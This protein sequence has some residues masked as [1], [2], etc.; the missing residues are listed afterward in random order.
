MRRTAEAFLFQSFHKNFVFFE[1]IMAM[2]VCCQTHWGELLVDTLLVV[3]VAV[4][5]VVVC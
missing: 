2:F 3:V 4:V 5:V 1:V